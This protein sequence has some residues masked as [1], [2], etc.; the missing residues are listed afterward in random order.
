MQSK[1]ILELFYSV[2]HGPDCL[3][4]ALRKQIE[5]RRGIIRAIAIPMVDVFPGPERTPHNFRHNK[6]ML[7][8]LPSFIGHRIF[9]AIH[10]QIAVRGFNQSGIPPRLCGPKLSAFFAAERKIPNSLFL[11]VII[12]SRNIVDK[13]AI[14][15]FNL[16][17]FFHKINMTYSSEQ[18]KPLVQGRPT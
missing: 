7:I 17:R 4:L 3:M 8:N 16:K 11:R 18:G 5:I 13:A 10:F 1:K 6:T 15:A 14:R 9:G 12:F 2:L